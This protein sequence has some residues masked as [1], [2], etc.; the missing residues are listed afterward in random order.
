MITAMN[1][2]ICTAQ[3][4]SV[5]ATW[6]AIVIVLVELAKS[7]RKTGLDKKAPR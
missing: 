7:F 4:V 2:A 1:G 5:A 6:L 3:F